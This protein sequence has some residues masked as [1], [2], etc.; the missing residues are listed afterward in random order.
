MINDR[1]STNVKY[2]GDRVLNAQLALI[3]QQ[4]NIEIDRNEKEQQSTFI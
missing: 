2:D 1:F 4:T 3:T